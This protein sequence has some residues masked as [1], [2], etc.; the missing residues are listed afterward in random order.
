MQ[1]KANED[2]Q[3]QKQAKNAMKGQA[4]HQR[5]ENASFTTKG[6]LNN[7]HI[8]SK[9]RQPGKFGRDMHLHF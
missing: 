7:H 8:E 9:L 1:K 4:R 6:P 3:K 5:E 2:V